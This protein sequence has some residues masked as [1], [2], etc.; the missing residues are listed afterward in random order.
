MQSKEVLYR[1]LLK[2]IAPKIILKNFDLTEIKE[3]NESITL[4]FEEKRE[5][6]PESLEGKEVVSAGFLN[7][8]ELQTFPVNDKK[9]FVSIKRRRWKTKGTDAPIYHN[10]YSLH[11]PGMKTTKEFGDFLKEELGLL[12]DEFNRFWEIPSD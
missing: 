1:E 10:S 12:P 2:L 9:L 8:V 4:L 11:R 5:M 3:Y 7:P 6:V